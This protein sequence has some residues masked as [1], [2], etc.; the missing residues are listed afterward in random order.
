[1]N[2]HHNPPI[3]AKE[4]WAFSTVPT[5]VRIRG[6]LYSILGPVRAR[7]SRPRRPSGR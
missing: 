4:I 2:V 3:G 1:M 5:N 7:T 6:E